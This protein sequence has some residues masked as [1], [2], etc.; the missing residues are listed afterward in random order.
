[1]TEIQSPGGAGRSFPQVDA[2]HFQYARFGSGKQ[3]GGNGGPLKSL[4]G[5][6]ASNIKLP[7]LLLETTH[8]ISLLA[9][10]MRAGCR[11]KSTDRPTGVC[12]G[13]ATHSALWGAGSCFR[14]ARR[15]ISCRAWRA[16]GWPSSMRI[17][18]LAASIVTGVTVGAAQLR[19]EV[20]QLR[21]LP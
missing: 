13:H 15:I 11:Q 7:G 8:M 4:Q 5:Q 1:M 14:P 21:H 9:K 10:T 16:V 19:I 12:S 18:R 17:N 20:L 2:E 6:P 3:V